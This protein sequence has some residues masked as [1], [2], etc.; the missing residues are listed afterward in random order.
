M[1]RTVMNLTR[2]LMTLGSAA[3]GAITALAAYAEAHRA[4]DQP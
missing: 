1:V 2:M 3:F 4:P